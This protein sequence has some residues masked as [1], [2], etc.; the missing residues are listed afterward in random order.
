MLDSISLSRF[1][2]TNSKLHK[3]NPISK[4]L[5]T[6]IFLILIFVDKSIEFNLILLLFLGVNIFLSSIPLKVYLKIFLGTL[7]FIIFI[8]L[9][10]FI[11]KTKIELSVLYTLRLILIVF[12]SSILT[13][14]TPTDE[15]IYGLKHLLSPLKIF[16]VPVNSL[17][18]ILS[19]AIRFI[20]SIFECGKNIIKV[21]DSRGI[22]FKSL[23]L[24]LKLSYIKSIIIPIF[25]LSFK[26]A[27]DVIDTMNLRLYN[28]NND[29]T[30]LHTYGYGKMDLYMIS[31]YTMLVMFII[32][33]GIY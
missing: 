31:L 27:D 12:S 28:C 30:D 23:S 8:F 22:S 17:A 33:K 32:M 2:N 25:V 4:I 20:P 11:C 26:N 1:Y 7:P 14:T 19:L 29:P 3:M 15:L 24:K 10:N 21:Y 13:L 16:K 5:C 18:L 9:I 6:F